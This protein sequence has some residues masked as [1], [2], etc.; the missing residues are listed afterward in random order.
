M[1]DS[2]GAI[3]DQTLEKQKKEYEED[4]SKIKAEIKTYDELNL[5]ELSDTELQKH[6]R[7]ME[8]LKSRAQRLFDKLTREISKANDA[9]EIGKRKK[10]LWEVFRDHVDG[11]KNELEGL[12]LAA[13]KENYSRL[14][15][16]AKLF[17][18]VPKDKQRKDESILFEKVSKNIGVLEKEY[19]KFKDKN[20]S[21]EKSEY[22]GLRKIGMNLKEIQSLNDELM[23]HVKNREIYLDQ[24]IH[25]AASRTNKDADDIRKDLF[26]AMGDRATSVVKINKENKKK[27]PEDLWSAVMELNDLAVSMNRFSSVAKS[28]LQETESEVKK[29]E[30]FRSKLK[31]EEIKRGSELRESIERKIKEEHAEFFN[32][33]TRNVAAL[34]ANRALKTSLTPSEAE[35]LIRKREFLDQLKIQ[36][37]LSIQLGI[38]YSVGK[39]VLSLCKMGA[40]K[41]EQFSTAAWKGAVE[42][43]DELGSQALHVVDMTLAAPVAMTMKAVNFSFNVVSTV[44][45]IPGSILFERPRD[46]IVEQFSSDFKDFDKLTGTEKGLK[47]GKWFAG[48]ILVLAASPLIIGGGV[49]RAISKGFDLLRQVCDYDRFSKKSRGF[50]TAAGTIGGLIMLALVI[51]APFTLG[52]SLIPVAAVGIGLAVSTLY[53]ARRAVTKA[54]TAAKEV[55]NLELSEEDSIRLALY[56]YD[57]P[58]KLAA[59]VEKE[60]RTSPVPGTELPD[61]AAQSA[62]TIAARVAT[63]GIVGASSAPRVA[64]DT[65]EGSKDRIS[66]PAAQGAVAAQVAGLREKVAD[67]KAELETAVAE[68]KRMEDVDAK[69]GKEVLHA[70]PTSPAP[71]ASAAAAAAAAS[72]PTPKPDD[73]PSGKPPAPPSV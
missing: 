54:A 53:S 50:N 28:K 36:Q 59:G 47:I 46:F 57:N 68:R 65:T 72:P 49:C 17:S 67:V 9:T 32:R 8:N 60:R 13:D 44:F 21:F 61:T 5:S 1:A 18:S 37:E 22:L 64:A 24:I 14:G 7:K 51:A 11:F 48:G 55:T 58:A 19:N 10:D 15:F 16:V 26:E 2:K 45:G 35:A 38:E 34:T 70:A 4:L 6:Q 25:L 71:Q 23:K 33:N 31:D 3:E 40:I 27:F 39:N 69:I 73:K 30:E 62:P 29:Y 52:F 43:V 66:A 12:L 42:V 56:E 63:L 20:E 41:A